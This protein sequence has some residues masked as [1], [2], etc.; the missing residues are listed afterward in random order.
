MTMPRGWRWLSPAQMTASSPT[1]SN[2]KPRLFEPKAGNG[3]EVAI[4][5]PYW[6]QLRAAPHPRRCGRDKR[7]GGGHGRGPA[8]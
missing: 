6:A 5:F 8:G 7:G 1:S 4:D 3:V 2:E